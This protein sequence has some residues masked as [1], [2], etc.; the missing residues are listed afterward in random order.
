[1]VRMCANVIILCMVSLPNDVHDTIH[2]MSE[3]QG[4]NHGIEI[5]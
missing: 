3:Q 4:I 5:L 2:V 1:M